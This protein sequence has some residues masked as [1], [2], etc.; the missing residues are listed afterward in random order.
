MYII[1]MVCMNYNK[2]DACIIHAEVKFEGT[3]ACILRLWSNYNVW[4][5]L[6]SL[7]SV[8]AWAKHLYYMSMGEYKMG[9][10]S[11][12]FKST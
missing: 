3:V 4:K 2:V 7:I 12:L 9:P 5:Q 8:I 11:S 6:L 10:F 1:I